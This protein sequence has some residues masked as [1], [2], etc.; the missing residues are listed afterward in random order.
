M[1]SYSV[2]VLTYICV[3]GVMLVVLQHLKAL[4]SEGNEES[5]NLSMYKM[6]LSFLKH[7]KRSESVLILERTPRLLI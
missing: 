6:G 4:L 1:Y 3:I 5:I 2:Y 7:S